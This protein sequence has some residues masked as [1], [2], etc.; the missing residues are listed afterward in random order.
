MSQ[1]RHLTLAAAGLA[2]GG[3]LVLGLASP[4]TA[5][6]PAGPAQGGTARVP[7]A[8][9]EIKREGAD[10]ISKRES[11]LTKLAERLRAAPS[12]DSG[13]KV[14]GVIAADGPALTELGNRLANDTN[15]A[16]ARRS[17][18]AIFDDYR[19]YLVVTPQAY[20]T[21]ACG[22]IQVAVD[23]LTKDQAALAT[24]VQAAAD[25]GA[26]MAKA[27]S[28]LTD[29][30]AELRDASTLADQADATL[31]A[32]GPDHGDKAVEA[33]NRAAVENAH[34]DLETARRDLT[35][36]VTDAREIVAEL[37]TAAG[38]RPTRMKAPGS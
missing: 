26:D 1:L 2:M 27:R 32:I 22:H 13:G 25:A 38:S 23:T 17:F 20:A 28:S 37:K 33:S 9:D 5:A 4:G 14:A 34:R 16:D 18:Q 21:S 12:C 3:A 11:Q 24:R 31:A 6:A 15:L 7:A 30:A 36:A 29:M 10:A 19:V 35:A 8:L